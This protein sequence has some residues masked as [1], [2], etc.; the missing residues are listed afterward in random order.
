MGFCGNAVVS[1]QLVSIFFTLLLSIRTAIPQ[2]LDETTL[3]E[4]RMSIKA[5]QWNTSDEDPCKWTGV[6][7]GG[8]RVVINLTLSNLKLTGSIPSSIGKLQSLNTLDLSRNALTGSI[9]AQ[10]SN[11]SN[12]SILIMSWNQ[13]S[14][15]IPH[16]LQ[17]LQRLSRLDL[18]H[19]FLTGSIPDKLGFLENL[20]HLDLSSNFLSG[21]IPGNFT[22][23]KNI[24][25]L[26]LSENLLTG[27][28]PPEIGNLSNLQTFFAYE[29]RL[30]GHIPLS[31]RNSKLQYVN[32]E[33][34]NLSGGVP[35]NICAA[36]KLE[37]LI[38]SSNNL[39]GVL[40]EELGSCVMLSNLR[41][42]DNSLW[43][44]I[45]A[46]FG[47]LS[48][49]TYLEADSNYL[50]G[51]IP[52][53]IGSWKNLSLLNLANNR[54][55]GGI[56][57]ELI[58]IPTLQELRLSQNLLSAEIP[59][60][61]SRCKNLSLLDLSGNNLSGNIPPDLCQAP[62]LRSL[63]LQENFISGSIPDTIGSCTQLLEL[64]LGSNR[65]DGSIPKEIGR[66]GHLQIALNLS[67][68]ELR[69]VIPDALGQLSNL[70]SLDLS[71]NHLSGEIPLS[72]GG[73]ISL[74]NFNFSSNDLHGPLPQSA[75]F[76]R[77][78][79]SSFADN[80][81]LCG[82][83]LPSCSST[84]SLGPVLNKRNIS[85][86][87]AAGIAIACGFVALVSIAVVAFLVMW[88]HA[89]SS[90]IDP[91]QPLIVSR[92]FVQRYLQAINFEIIKEATCSSANIIASNHFSTFYK[93]M[94]PSGL[95]LIAKKLHCAEKGVTIHQRRMILELDKMGKVYHDNVMHLVAYVL[96]DDT[97]ILIYDFV[98]RCSLAQQLHG[99][100]QQTIDWFAR[101]NIALQVAHGLAFLHHSCH[102]PMIHMDIT[103]NTIF[104]GSG[105]EVKIGDIEIT[106]LI[107]PSKNTGS[108]TAVAGSFGYIAPEYAFTMQV[109]LASNV[110]SFGVVL[111]ELVTGRH[112]IDETFGEGIDLVR[113][114][115][116]APSRGETPEQILDDRISTLSFA[117]RQEML[118]VLKVA[119]LCTSASPSRRPRMKK[120]VELL[121]E[122]NPS[123]E[124]TQIQELVQ[125]GEKKHLFHV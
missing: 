38:L 73:M 8:A 122:T 101:Y 114:V 39:T 83:P 72:L 41:L 9:P 14:S 123:A 88:R 96:Q 87:Q 61:L 111:L 3:R 46:Q 35:G 120:V 11:C 4:L 17:Q 71:H 62:K 67:S 45:P 90:A 65:L 22:Y 119:L 84:S 20:Q 110:Y 103:S 117:S 49:L 55:T 94:M 26:S 64:Q 99:D 91:R 40:P 59:K 52:S 57:I 93:A 78:S 118:A 28:I 31:A 12:L 66:L 113:W 13:L 92:V 42:G 2:T 24:S 15:S 89:Q 21:R 109:T 25:F 1:L 80:P 37:V 19:N 82:S 70:V 104:L 76:S 54:L 51:E 77:S 6:V 48:H 98:P 27:S 125:G 112:P 10:I 63:S 18:S 36:G 30:E 7:C 85:F 33:S 121:V 106:K 79:I 43:G 95:I 107:D 53:I 108:I 102:P 97:A 58:N 124:D 116:T 100:S 56:P 34:N 23:L 44:A 16:E 105:F 69:G 50:N 47:Q 60:G 115:H 75:V 86:W 29:N 32:L 74:L 68:N 81:G 5:S